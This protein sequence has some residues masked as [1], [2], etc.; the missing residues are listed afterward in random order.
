MDYCDG[1]RS[2]NLMATPGLIFTFQL[3]P[4]LDK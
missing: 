3:P 4:E 2:V 1:T